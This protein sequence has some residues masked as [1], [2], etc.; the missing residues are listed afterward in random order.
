MH[1]VR[2]AEKFIEDESIPINVYAVNKQVLVAEVK[3][4]QKE[5]TKNAGLLGVL[6]I[7][8]MTF[9]MRSLFLAFACMM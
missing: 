4:A 2:L 7:G 1:L 5:A 9:H 8:Y 3:T 6:V